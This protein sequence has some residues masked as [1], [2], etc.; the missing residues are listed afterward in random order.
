MRDIMLGIIWAA[1]ATVSFV[2]ASTA[3]TMPPVSPECNLRNGMKITDCDDLRQQWLTGN[4]QQFNI[5][6]VSNPVIWVGAGCANWPLPDGG[7][8]V[9]FIFLIRKTV[10]V[11]E[12]LTL[13]I[14]A[15]LSL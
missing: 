12:E 1:A 9:G 10:I 8:K 11:S 13:L 7:C 2:T 6:N 3:S 14:K 5:H 15:I 4:C